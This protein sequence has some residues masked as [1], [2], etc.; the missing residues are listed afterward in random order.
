[1]NYFECGQDGFFTS[2]F[3]YVDC[4]QYLADNFFINNNIYVDFL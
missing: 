1:M 3:M 2:T 4:N